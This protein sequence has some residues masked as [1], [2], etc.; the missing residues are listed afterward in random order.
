MNRYPNCAIALALLL[1]LMG[2][3]WLWNDRAIPYERPRGR[4]QAEQVKVDRVQ[5]RV[6]Y[7]YTVVD[8]PE[9]IWIDLGK[10]LKR[11]AVRRS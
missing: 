9:G 1:L 7:G 2:A 11:W 5:A 10:G 8:V 6:G 4:T 3:V